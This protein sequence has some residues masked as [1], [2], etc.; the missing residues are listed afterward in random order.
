MSILILKMLNSL[1]ITTNEYV[2]DVQYVEPVYWVM[3]LGK[4]YQ[5]HSNFI[6]L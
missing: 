3:K 2:Q 4:S 6:I 5:K 1:E